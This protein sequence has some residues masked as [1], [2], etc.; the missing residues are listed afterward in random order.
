MHTIATLSGCISF[1]MV[2][3]Q[4]LPDA[5]AWYDYHPPPSLSSP[6]FRFKVKTP[7][8]VF[9]VPPARTPRPWELNRSWTW[10]GAKLTLTFQYVF[11]KQFSKLVWYHQEL[12]SRFCTHIFGLAMT[13]CKFAAGN[14]PATVHMDKQWQTSWTTSDVWNYNFDG[15]KPGVIKLPI[16]GRSNNPN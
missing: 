5:I 8:A 1:F 13:C 12:I 4:K 7:P 3:V 6:F 10:H 15:I 2:F 9:L 14:N 11:F 16:M